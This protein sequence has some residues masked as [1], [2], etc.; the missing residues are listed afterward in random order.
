MYFLASARSPATWSA[1]GTQESVLAREAH[2]TSD[3]DAISL[4]QALLEQR[5]IKVSYSMDD[6]DR[7]DRA[8]LDA[9]RDHGAARLQLR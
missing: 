7:E 2:G 8:R 6:L 1:S 5:P 4:A 9:I 3:K